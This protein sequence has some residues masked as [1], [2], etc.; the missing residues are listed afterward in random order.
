MSKKFVVAAGEFKA[1]CL[2]LMDEVDERGMEITITKRGR[3]VARLVSTKP[4]TLSPHQLYGAMAGMA[5]ITGDI[6]A[7]LDVNWEA[8]R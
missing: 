5:V 1:R 6:E 8:D 4:R 7:S 3:P 2:H